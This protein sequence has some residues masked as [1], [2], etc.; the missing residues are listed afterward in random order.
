MFTKNNNSK[1]K[2]EID[3]KVNLCSHWIVFSFKKFATI[4]KEERSDSLK[5]LI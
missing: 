5:D 1:V 4:D 3:G 2:S